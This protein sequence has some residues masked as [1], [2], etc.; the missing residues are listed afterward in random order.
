MKTSVLCI[1]LLFAILPAANLSYGQNVAVAKPKPPK[2]PK[3]PEV[4]I[5]GGISALLAAGISLGAAK[6]MQKKKQA[7]M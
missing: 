1:G 3:P 2:P 7:E 4:P 5:D 6:M